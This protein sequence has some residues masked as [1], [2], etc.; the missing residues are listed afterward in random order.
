MSSLLQNFA[1]KNGIYLSQWV[2]K[3][4]KWASHSFIFSFTFTC[5][6]DQITIK[7]KALR[8]RFQVSVALRLPCSWEYGCWRSWGSF[9]TGLWPT[10]DCGTSTYSVCILCIYIYNI[11]HI[12]SLPITFQCILTADSK[13]ITKAMTIQFTFSA[14]KT[15]LNV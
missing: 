13:G 6:R 7:A 15:H 4:L 9:T 11:Y 10:F 1:I 3:K 5:C 8:R 2:R 12:Q 14:I